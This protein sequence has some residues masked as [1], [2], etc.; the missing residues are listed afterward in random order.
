MGAIMKKFIYILIFSIIPGL[1]CGESDAVDILQKDP[2]KINHS[3]ITLNFEFNN[4]QQVI[5][6]IPEPPFAF[7]YY[8]KIIPSKINGEA[9]EIDTFVYLADAELVSVLEEMLNKHR[10]VY[11]KAEVYFIDTDYVDTT[12]GKIFNREYM[13]IANINNSMIT[14]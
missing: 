11:M 4:G 1:S 14:Y 3:Y 10:T 13:F 2:D 7:P 6:E 12:T 8:G 5:H 9:M